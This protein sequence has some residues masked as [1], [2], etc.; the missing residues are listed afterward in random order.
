MA[1]P[2]RRADQRRVTDVPDESKL[3]VFD[4]YVRVS[5]VGGRDRDAGRFISPKLQRERIA[6][7]QMTHGDDKVRIGEWFE[8]VDVS[9]ATVADE[10]PGLKRAFE[11][12][13][14][15]QSDGIV[16]AQL[17]RFS[18][19]VAGALRDLDWLR[20]HGAEFASVGDSIDTT[21]P[22]GEF[23]FTIVL[24]MA[25]LERAQRAEG[26]ERARRDAVVERGWQLTSE[27]VAGTCSGRSHSNRTPSGGRSSRRCSPTSP[28][29][30][31]RA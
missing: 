11:R 15:G 16:V 22:N 10:R 18:R 9:G 17:D 30:T 4:A 3:K 26:W 31:T 13:E 14:R 7:W 27:G 6:G 28:V 19:S 23:L 20:E 12:I 24:A 5:R 8:D 2:G 1:L 25:Q 29:G 21:T